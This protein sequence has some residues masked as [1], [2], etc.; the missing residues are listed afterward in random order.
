[1][2]DHPAPN[3]FAN[4]PQWR[5]AALVASAVAAVEL[6][7]LLAAAV[8]LFEPFADG[9]EEKAAVAVVQEKAKVTAQPQASPQ[10][11]AAE[12]TPAQPAAAQPATPEQQAKPPAELTRKQT[13]VLVLNGNGRTGAAAEAAGVVGGFGYKIAG[14]ENAPRTDF[15]SSVVMFRPGFKAEAQRLAK[16]VRVTRVTPLDGLKPGDLGGAQVVLVVGA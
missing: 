8:V 3:R 5:S 14:T 6:I 15:A 16:D 2:V 9:V 10:P 7:L 11:A 13:S 12:E 1:M 4:A